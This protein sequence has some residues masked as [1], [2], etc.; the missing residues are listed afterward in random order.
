[1]NSNIVK[2]AE[3]EWFRLKERRKNAFVVISAGMS[4]GM[5]IKNK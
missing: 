1:M 2:A 5:L 4:G 3:K